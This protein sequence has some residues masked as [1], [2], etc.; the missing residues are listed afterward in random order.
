MS[1]PPPPPPPKKQKKSKK[2]AQTSESSSSESDS[3]IIPI[4]FEF[5]DPQPQDFHGI[6][7]LLRQLFDADSPLLDLS[8]LTDTI[9]S[10]SLLGTTVKV[11]GR[12][13]DPFFFLTVL[14]L[15]LCGEVEG[16]KGL[17]GYVRSVTESTGLGGVLAPLLS[18]GDEVNVAVV[19]SERL[20]N[21]PADISPPAY[22]MLLE[23]IQAAVEDNEP[24]NF[25]HYLLLSKSYKEIESTLPPTSPELPAQKRLKPTKKSKKEKKREEGKIFD[26]HPEDATFQKHSIDGMVYAYKNE[27]PP[28]MADSKRAF[29]EV[30]VVACGRVM[31]MSKEGFE[32]AVGEL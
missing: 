17:V 26:F 2:R 23:E 16:V 32:R 31:L 9:I 4:D 18:G 6:K 1:P 5:F 3:E 24:Y 30:G 28:E 29:Q 12:D 15:R 19:L 7:T 20:I 13:G 8:S 14:N 22:R 21:M 10:Q 27:P 25:T 11:D